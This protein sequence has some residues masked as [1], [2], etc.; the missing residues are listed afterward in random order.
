MSS[1]HWRQHYAQGD[2][3]TQGQ[4]G[5]DQ[6]Q[7][8][9]ANQNQVLLGQGLQLGPACTP[10]ER[11]F[12]DAVQSGQSVYEARM[13]MLISRVPEELRQRAIRAMAA[14]M[15]ASRDNDAAWKELNE[16]GIDGRGNC[17]GFD[18]FYDGI[19]AAAR[20]L[21]GIPKDE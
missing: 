15:M 7:Q 18:S 9:M 8:Q 21:A 5:V 11:A 13:T 19:R 1:E 6:M 4:L 2:L 3:T 12:L 14:Q 16:L 20:E 10:E 17:K